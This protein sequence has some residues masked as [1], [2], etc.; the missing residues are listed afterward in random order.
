MSTSVIFFKEQK[1]K[2]SKNDTYKCH[3]LEKYVS[4]TIGKKWEIL[5]MF[6]LYLLVRRIEIPLYFIS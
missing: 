6:I 2:K 1:G 5:L 4:I 3:F